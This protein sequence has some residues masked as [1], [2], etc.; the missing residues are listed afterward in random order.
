MHG[1]RDF[2]HWPIINYYFFGQNRSMKIQNLIF[3]VCSPIN[4]ISIPHLQ[5]QSTVRCHQI[6]LFHFFYWICHTNSLNTM[7]LIY[8]EV[9]SN[10][11]WLQSNLKGILLYGMARY[12]FPWIDIIW[13][14]WG[15]STIF[16]NPLLISLLW[17]MDIR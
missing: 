2:Q 10:P 1:Y 9:M 6:H 3:M 7:L 14:V 8:D 17:L 4:N 15:F 5:F 12:P 11:D 13:L 16:Y